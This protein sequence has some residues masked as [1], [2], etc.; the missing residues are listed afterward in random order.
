ML[1]RLI[2]RVS[3]RIVIFLFIFVLAADT[4]INQEQTHRLYMEKY[5]NFRDMLYLKRIF[6]WP[7]AKYVKISN[8]F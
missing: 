1:S 4:Y 7:P 3:G 8:N 2:M 6:N 5:D